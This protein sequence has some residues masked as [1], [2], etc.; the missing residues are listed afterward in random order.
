MTKKEFLII[1][2]IVLVVLIFVIT[3]ALLKEVKSENQTKKFA[4]N[5]I[6]RQ[7]TR[8]E[9]I[10]DTG[11]YKIK[12]LGGDVTITIGKNEYSL[13]EALQNNII[14]GNDILSKIKA[15]DERGICIA[16]TI[17]DGGTRTYKYKDYTVLKLN[18]IHENTN[19]ITR[20]KDLI[21]GMRGMDLDI[22][23]RNK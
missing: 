21:I 11:E 9:E 6:A 19:G 12:T 7:D 15:D 3:F 1:T 13:K 14:T 10:Y 20:E 5:Y 2:I 23:D 16:Y 18:A 8:V 4:I 22:Y 17:A